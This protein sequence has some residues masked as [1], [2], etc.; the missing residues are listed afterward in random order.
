[1]RKAVTKLLKRFTAF[2]LLLCTAF[3]VVG[4]KDEGENSESEKETVSVVE[5]PSF[6]GVHDFT[7]PEVATEDYILKNGVF[8]YTLVI[9]ETPSSALEVARQEFVLLFKRATGVTISS[10]VRDDTVRYDENAKYISFGDN[11]YTESANIEYD[12]QGLK[13]DG[14]RIITKGKSI[15]LLGGLD[16]GVITA[17]YDFMQICFHYE[18]YYRNCVQIDTGVTDLKLKNFDVTDVPDIDNRYVSHANGS[19]FDAKKE[20]DTKAFGET[21]AQDVLNRRERY[22]DYNN[23]GSLMLPIYTEFNNPSSKSA[24]FHNVFEYC[25]PSDPTTD[26]KWIADTGMQCCF[27]AR[28]D[29]TALQNMKQHFANKIINTLTL[30]PADKNPYGSVVTITSEDNDDHCNCETCMEGYANDGESRNG[31]AIRFCNDVIDIVYDWMEKPENEAYKRDLTVIFFAYGSVCK[32]PAIQNAET[33]EWEAAENCEM[34]EHTGVFYAPGRE[35]CFYADIHDPVNQRGKDFLDAWMNMT[36]N[37]YFWGYGGFHKTSCYYMNNENYFDNDFF[38]ILASGNCRYFFNEVLDGGEDQTAWNNLKTYLQ[39]KLSWDCNLDVNTLVN[40]YFKAM[41][42]DAS[43]TMLELYHSHRLFFDYTMLKN[44]AVKINN[45]FYA[46]WAEK[47]IYPYPVLQEYMAKIDQALADIEKYKTSNP[48]LYDVVKSRI[49][50]EA[51]SYLYM[52][53]DIHG[54]KAI[55]SFDEETKF[56]YKDRLYNILVN[57]PKLGSVSNATA[58]AIDI[59]K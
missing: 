49:E 25:P 43:D 35:F 5:G 58:Y 47:T 45:G 2:T 18:Y 36:E 17:V 44:E 1:M 39:Y 57:Y 3:S 8:Q 6:E 15:F 29:E 4:C 24:G 21:A 42:K 51:V 34:G 33:G 7:A 50:L 10:I 40:N 16:T 48:D 41:Y 27:T 23:F 53:L 38:R 37:L 26:E 56:A 20:V 31:V 13:N 12:K 54:A 14:G 11:K 59:C 22:R 55:P 19:E 9:P 28:G 52:I 46:S 32:P 30:I